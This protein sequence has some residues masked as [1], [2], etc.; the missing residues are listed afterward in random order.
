[1]ASLVFVIYV[2]YFGSRSPEKAKSLEINLSWR[3]ETIDTGLEHFKGY[4]H[5]AVGFV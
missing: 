2:S 4:W 3:T 1:M 5:K